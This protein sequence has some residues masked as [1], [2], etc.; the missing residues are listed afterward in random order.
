M[1][2]TMSCN[3]AEHVSDFSEAELHEQASRLALPDRYDLYLRVYASSTPRNPLLASDIVALGEPAR[4][5]VLEQMTRANS[6]QLG[7]A[8]AVLSQYRRGCR[9]DEERKLL[10]AASRLDGDVEVR[11]A[12]SHAIEVACLRDRRS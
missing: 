2:L 11:E 4:A 7:A 10:N 5:Y 8:L 12:W 3:E 9:E 1:F 6:M